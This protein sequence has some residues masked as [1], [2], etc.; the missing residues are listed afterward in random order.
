MTKVAAF[1]QRGHR[2]DSAVPVDFGS[3]QRR[4]C[5]TENSLSQPVP[6]LRMG[7]HLCVLS[8]LPQRHKDTKTHVRSKDTK[9]QFE[10]TTTTPDTPTA[11]EINGLCTATWSQSRETVPADS[12]LFVVSTWFH[13]QWKKEK[14]RP[15]RSTATCRRTHLDDRLVLTTDCAA[16]VTLSQSPCLTA[17]YLAEQPRSG[18]SV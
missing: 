1:V 6:L 10:D 3:I 5:Q 15:R 9:S 11:F 12:R 17:G 7:V 8:N 14:N 16:L 2:E 4:C 18:D 13:V